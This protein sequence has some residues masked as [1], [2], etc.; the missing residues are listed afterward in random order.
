MAANLNLG[1]FSIEVFL[2][3]EEDSAYSLKRDNDPKV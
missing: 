2:L 1:I 3:N